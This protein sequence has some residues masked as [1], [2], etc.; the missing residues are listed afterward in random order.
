MFPNKSY[1]YATEYQRAVTAEKN[2]NLKRDLIFMAMCRR[3][4]YQGVVKVANNFA[5][6]LLFV[7]NML[8][9][10]QTTN[11]LHKQWSQFKSNAAFL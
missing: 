4:S 8:H 1:N 9:E 10:Q 7:N 11:T 3:S 5:V 6:K 2:K